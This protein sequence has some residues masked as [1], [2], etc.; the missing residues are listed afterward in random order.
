V[1]VLDVLGLVA[2]V[3]TGVGVAV[4]LAFTVAGFWRRR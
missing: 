2:A 1:S 3:A 4:M